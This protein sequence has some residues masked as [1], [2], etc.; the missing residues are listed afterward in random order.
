MLD[1]L[2]VDFIVG[3][4][5]MVGELFLADFMGIDRFSMGAFILVVLIGSIA[6]LML[7]GKKRVR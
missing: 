7:G 5:E 4:C 3:N 6:T 2:V 1:R